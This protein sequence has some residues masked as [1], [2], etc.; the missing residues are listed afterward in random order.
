MSMLNLIGFYIH[1][2]IRSGYSTTSI[3]F[4]GE[5]VDSIIILNILTVISPTKDVSVKNSRPLLNFWSA[6]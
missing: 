1:T 6:L 4:A 3:K 2:G 5:H